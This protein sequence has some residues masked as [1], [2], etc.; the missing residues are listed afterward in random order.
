MP[1]LKSRATP[2]PEGRY[3]PVRPRQPSQVP[4][5]SLSA[6]SSSPTP[7]MPSPIHMSPF[8][9]GSLPSIAT[10]V[11]VGVLNQFYGGKVLPR[12]QTILPK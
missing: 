11:T 3:Q 1:S 6:G 9:L 12:R 10:N 2:L 4:G 5:P 8:M 7:P